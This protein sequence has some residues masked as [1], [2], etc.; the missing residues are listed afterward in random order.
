MKKVK[1]SDA[2]PMIERGDVLLYRGFSFVSFL[3]SGFTD[4]VYTHV[5]VVDKF[6]LDGEP[7]CELVQFREFKGGMASSLWRDVE[8]YS[9]KIDVFRPER[10]AEVSEYDETT[11]SVKTVAV[12]FDS[13]RV[14]SKMR[15]ITGQEYGYAR[16]LALWFRAAP[17]ARFFT[18]KSVL[19]ATPE[20]LVFPVCSSSVSWCFSKT[21][22]LLVRKNP[23]WT[24]PG[25]LAY[26]PRL[27]YLFTLEKD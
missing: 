22:Y 20:R 13:E 11:K 19:N 27:S 2:A 5:A 17:L 24:T 14:L 18:P 23:N 21:G 4:S 26:S 3:I 15:K 9:G 7:F 6:D 8:K 1:F 10:S 25:D 16:I 12:P